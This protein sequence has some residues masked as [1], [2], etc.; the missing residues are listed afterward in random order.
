M[1]AAVFSKGHRRPVRTWRWVRR[2]WHHEV[3]TRCSTGS[4]HGSPTLHDERLLAS[5]GRHAMPC[6]CVIR[7]DTCAVCIDI[8]SLWREL[9]P[10]DRMVREVEQRKREREMPASV[11]IHGIAWPSARIAS[12]DGWSSTYVNNNACSL[13]ETTA[14]KAGQAQHTQPLSLS[15]SL[16]LWI[17]CLLSFAVCR[18]ASCS[19][20]IHIAT[21]RRCGQP[22]FFGLG[23]HP[24]AAV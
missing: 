15:P 20:Q 5:R 6:K 8:L 18:W 13:G 17:S 24:A 10:R 11:V 7:D 4:V 22:D 23:Q 16:S 14:N 21:S 9:R 12:A 3:L 1:L 19:R 2:S